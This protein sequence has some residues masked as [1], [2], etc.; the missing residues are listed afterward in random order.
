VR[1]IPTVETE[2]FPSSISVSETPLS[3]PVLLTVEEYLGLLPITYGSWEWKDA[4]VLLLRDVSFRESFGMYPAGSRCLWMYVN[5]RWNEVWSA[6]GRQRFLVQLGLRYG[7]SRPPW[8][9]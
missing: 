2:E 4:E 9:G 5:T 7:G 3:E 8:C 6:A 1:C